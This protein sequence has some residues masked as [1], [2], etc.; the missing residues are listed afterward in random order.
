MTWALGPD[1]GAEELEHWEAMINTIFVPG[2][3]GRI[4]YQY[5]R[6]RLSPD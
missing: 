6:S 1:I 5:N 2:F 4:A 3:S